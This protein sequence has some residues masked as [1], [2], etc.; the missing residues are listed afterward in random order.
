[1]ACFDSSGSGEWLS[2]HVVMTRSGALH[3]LDTPETMQPLGC[4]PA[5]TR[6]Q[7]EPADAPALTLT[8]RA[9]SAK[10]LFVPRSR[11]Y[12]FRAPSVEECCEW[13]AALREA[14]GHS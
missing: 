5:L 2:C 8:E 1:M 11:R 10:T 13:V 3:W 7:F 4:V 6:C 9:A 12:S 14:M